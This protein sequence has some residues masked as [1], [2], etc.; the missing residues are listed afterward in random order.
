MNGFILKII[1]IK[2]LHICIIPSMN[3]PTGCNKCLPNGTDFIKVGKCA[4][5]L[6]SNYRLFLKQNK[7][8]SSTYFVSLW[9]I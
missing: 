5:K 3:L 2:P 7:N 4:T 8:Y 1:L 6:T 9:Q